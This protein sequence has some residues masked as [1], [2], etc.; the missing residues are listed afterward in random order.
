MSSTFGS[1]SINWTW[2]ATLSRTLDPRFIQLAAVTV[3]LPFGQPKSI[4]ARL[5]MELADWVRRTTVVEKQNTGNLCRRHR[6]IIIASFSAGHRFALGIRL[7]TSIFSLKP[8]GSREWSNPVGARNGDRLIPSIIIS[9]NRFHNIITFLDKILSGS[10]DENSK[11]EGF[12][13]RLVPPVFRRD[14]LVLFSGCRIMQDLSKIPASGGGMQ[15]C[16]LANVFSN[17]PGLPVVILH[18]CDELLRRRVKCQIKPLRVLQGQSS[19]AEGTRG[20]PG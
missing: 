14:G 8:S 19:F 18:S 13:T 10:L 11:A 4:D 12:S 16:S 2:A 17:F 20:A 9:K 15:L 7:P 3:P 6:P 5:A 1:I